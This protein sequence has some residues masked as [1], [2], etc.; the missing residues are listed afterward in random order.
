[1]SR[2]WWSD[3]VAELDQ[4]ATPVMR[5]GAGFDADQTGWQLSEERKELR[6]P[7]LLSDDYHAALVD[8]VHLEHRLRDVQPNR[9]RLTHA[10]LHLCESLHS[11]GGGEPSTASTPVVRRFG[12]NVQEGSE[13]A[14]L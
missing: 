6:P 14:S 12:R 10:L 13:A 9:D 8:A 1:M 4:L 5:R 7:D 2:T 11:R 3:L